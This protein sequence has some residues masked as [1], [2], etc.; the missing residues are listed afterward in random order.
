[1][2]VLR[3]RLLL[4]AVALFALVVVPVAVAGAAGDSGEPQAKASGG[5]KEKVRNLKRRLKGLE[6][7][8]AEF[9]AIPGPAGP[10]GPPGP[11]GP[12]G[13]PGGL[14]SVTRSVNLPI[15]SFVNLVPQGTI[16]FSPSNGTA[17]DFTTTATHF[18]I[19]WDADQDG[20]G[21]DV[22]DTGFVASTF[23]VPPDHA[24]GGH[25]RLGVSKNGHSG[26]AERLRCQVVIN[27][28]G[29]SSIGNLTTTSSAN[30]LYTVL[31]PGVTYAAGDRVFVTCAVDDGSGGTTANNVVRLHGIEFRYTATQ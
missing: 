19:T 31:I 4:A 17:T 13:P 3:T 20:G 27:G 29:L 26:P 12:A 14:S 7:E 30:T 2:N 22:A 1:M 28:G 6:Q 24:S 9:E 5:L 11:P 15:G 10:S 16:D 8:F 25:F 23:I 21:S 18:S